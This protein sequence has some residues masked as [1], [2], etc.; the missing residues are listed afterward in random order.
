[1]SFL[2]LRNDARDSAP[3]SVCDSD[4]FS[5]KSFGN[6]QEEAGSYTLLPGYTSRP[7]ISP[8]KRNSQQPHQKPHQ[9]GGFCTAADQ[10][11]LHTDHKQTPARRSLYQKFGGAPENAH[12]TS[13]QK[14]VEGGRSGSGSAAQQVSAWASA[15]H[16]AAQSS[17]A[18][19]Q[20]ESVR[21]VGAVTA[22]HDSAKH[23]SSE[24][25]DLSWQLLAE[26][27]PVSAQQPAP[28]A[29]AAPKEALKPSSRHQ[30]PQP[31]A[32]GKSCTRRTEHA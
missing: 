1:M 27:E 12:P 25:S 7:N 23:D 22:Q 9:D 13:E 14:G 20:P 18:P 17:A 31:S 26:G 2:C 28:S 32:A 19:A 3:M 10:A 8:E 11:E 21:P 24:P 30:S 16:R 6:L 29:T 5:I 4:Q 15:N